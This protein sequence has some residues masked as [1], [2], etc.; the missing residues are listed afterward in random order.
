ML[1]QNI[2]IVIFLIFF[3]LFWKWCHIFSGA[4]AKIR[5]FLRGHGGG[6]EPKN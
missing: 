4:V 1:F 3:D 5:G 2:T 6:G